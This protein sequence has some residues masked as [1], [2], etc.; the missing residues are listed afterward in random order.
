MCTHGHITQ[1]Y[2][3]I[4]IVFKLTNISNIIDKSFVIISLK[5]VVWEKE[6]Q[7]CFFDPFAPPSFKVPCFLSFDFF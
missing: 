5:L 6:D 3:N 4:Q 1:I 2:K 7:T